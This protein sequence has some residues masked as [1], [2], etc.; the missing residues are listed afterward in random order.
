MF[1]HTRVY[2]PLIEA[3]LRG[4]AKHIKMLL[5]I[6]MNP[7]QRDAIER[8]PLIIITHY[9]DEDKAMLLAEEI[10][11]CG[12]KIE[13][14]DAK[15]M[16]AVHHVCQKGKIKLAGLLLEYKDDYDVFVKDGSGKTCLDY[17][18]ITE[19][20][21]LVKI[22]NNI[23]TDFGIVFHTKKGSFA[24]ETASLRNH[25]KSDYDTAAIKN[26]DNKDL[27][28]DL[29]RENFSARKH[30]KLCHNDKR[31]KTVSA[32]KT[33]HGPCR[34]GFSSKQRTSNSYTGRH[35]AS[36]LGMKKD[37]Q[38]QGVVGSLRK[39]DSQSSEAQTQ[40]ASKDKETVSTDSS[41]KRGSS[42]G[43]L[44]KI[45][46]LYEK[47]TSAAYREAAKKPIIEDLCERSNAE[48]PALSISPLPDSVP[49]YSSRTASRR[50]NRSKSLVPG[51]MTNLLSLR[52]A[53]PNTM[54][55]P[56]SLRQRRFSTAI[57]SNDFNV[58][59]GTRNSLEGEDL[60]KRPNSLRQRRLSTLSATNNGL[61]QNNDAGKSNPWQ[62][63]DRMKRPRSLQPR[64]FSSLTPVS[65][66]PELNDN[67]SNIL[68]LS[69]P[70]LTAI[71]EYNEERKAFKN[72]N[73][74]SERDVQE[75]DRKSMSGGLRRTISTLPTLQTFAEKEETQES[76]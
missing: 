64:R 16:N 76:S 58:P 57:T 10:I 43:L 23:A 24:E 51:A 37:S 30:S 38:N 71:R 19:N 22:L 42:K 66:R 59:G 27:E 3:L 44:V 54:H 18:E 1:P 62:T 32:T 20:K 41:K 73:R 40:D 47:Q 45:Y 21:V 12:G 29:K 70:N 7:N 25:K 4:N 75:S 63:N 11:N 39:G 35:R 28:G 55:R 68:S 36:S 50:S 14:S 61:G 52:S 17:A 8:T 53:S 67:T 69:A 9:K 15:G 72:G 2:S 65:S 6:G 46:K 34:E 13:L 26:G 33:I 5:K 49:G 74:G 56:R 31:H 48:S 60:P